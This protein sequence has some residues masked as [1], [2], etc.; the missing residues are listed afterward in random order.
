MKSNH[1][2]V[3]LEP[4]KVEHRVV[5]KLV[6]K[7]NC[8]SDQHRFRRRGV[9]VIMGLALQSLSCVYGVLPAWAQAGPPTSEPQTQTQDSTP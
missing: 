3:C 4:H 7:N 9:A 6:T 1:R 8:G 5:L 2:V